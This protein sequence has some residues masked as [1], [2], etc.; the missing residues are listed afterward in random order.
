MQN[1]FPTI[2][3][4][5]IKKIVYKVKNMY[6]SNHLKVEELIVNRGSWHD[7]SYILDDNL[8]I[9]KLKTFVLC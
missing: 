1:Y 4:Q 8:C 2:N 7:S 5:I 3:Y 9:I 6:N